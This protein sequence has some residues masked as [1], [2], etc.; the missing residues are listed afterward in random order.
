MITA[1][2][3]SRFGLT[4]DTQDTTGTVL[5][6]CDRRVTRGV[7]AVALPQLWWSPQADAADVFGAQ[8]RR[9]EAL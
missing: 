3:R 9:A 6:R 5:S 8:G 2:E 4:T 7:G 1:A